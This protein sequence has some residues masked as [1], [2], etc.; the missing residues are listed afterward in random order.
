MK[1][2]VSGLLCCLVLLLL[3]PALSL[4]EGESFT[5]IATRADWALLQANPEGN[6]ALM[7]DIDM[8][9]EPWT[10]LP[11]SGKLEGNGHTLYNL[12]VSAPGPHT[13]TTYDGNRKQY[14]TVFGGLFS[15][16]DHAQVRNLNL[17][18]AVIEIETDQHCFIGTLAGYAAS[19]AFEN[20]AVQARNHLTLTSVNAGVGGLAGFSLDSSFIGC[21]ADTEL[22]FTDTNKNKLCEAFLGGIYSSGCGD[23]RN[24]AVRLRG[25]AEVYGYIHSGGVIGMAKLPRGARGVSQLTGTEVEAEISFFEITPS[26]RAYCDALVGENLAGDCRTTRNTILSFQRHESRTA[27]RLAPELC[28]PPRYREEVTP[29]TCTA[30]GYTTFTCESCGY[31]YRDFYTPPQHQEA[32]D[33]VTAP[34]CTEAG[35]TVYRCALCGQTRREEIPPAGHRYEE[36]VLSPTCTQAGAAIYTCARCGDSY[37]EPLPPTGHTPG[38]WTETKAPQ[39]NQA[40]EEQRFC[41]TCGQALESRPIDA[42]PYTPTEGVALTPEALSLTVGQ[43]ARLTARVLPADAS[44]TEVRFASSDAAV[45]CVLPD[46]TVQ[47]LRPGTAA[48]T[49][50]AADGQQSACLVTVAYSPWQW[51]RHYILFGWLLED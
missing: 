20:C 42:L 12:R 22:T 34:T 4:A 41:Q 9:G 8:G 35:E 28:E 2:I 32:V 27:T 51:I 7:A 25:F 17:V 6:F 3:C 39:V 5:P 47:A 33:S 43:A 29:G 26:R 31:S 30:W 50:I 24:C 15:V 49:C 44:D 21:R 48:I 16:A 18:N 23:V 11:F 46:G 19:S 36:S 1:R 45:A 10:P 38:P 37:Q 14:E 40:G 13:A